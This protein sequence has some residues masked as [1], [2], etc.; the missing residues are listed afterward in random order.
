M[1]LVIWKKDRTKQMNRHSNGVFG[2][3]LDGTGLLKAMKL[4]D[5]DPKDAEISKLNFFKHAR[6]MVRV[7][8]THSIPSSYENAKTPPN[9]KSPLSV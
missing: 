1:E 8:A 4:V 3:E 7:L 2:K 6:M 5:L 9:S